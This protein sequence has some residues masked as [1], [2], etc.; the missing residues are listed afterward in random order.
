MNTQQAHSR[1]ARLW[2]SAA[3]VATSLFL[4]PVA[5]GQASASDDSAAAGAAAPETMMLQLYDGSILWGSIVGHDSQTLHFQ[6]LDNGG[7]VRLPWPQLA[8][9]LAD[10]LLDRYGYIDRSGEEII[11]EADRLFLRDG[12][13]VIGAIVNRTEDAIWIKTA[14]STF[15]V[16]KL[17]LRGASTRVKVSAL[18]IYTRD[19]LY[20]NELA[21]LDPTSAQSEWDMSIYCER[22]YDFAHALEHLAAAKALDPNFKPNEIAAAVERNTA[23]VALQTQIDALREIDTL[24]VRGKFDEALKQVEAFVA[25]FETS[26]L[27]S[28]AN[29]K[30]AQVLKAREQKMRERVVEAWHVWLPRLLQTKARSPE[31]TLEAAMAYV[32]EGLSRELLE[33]VTKE[34][35]KTVSSEATPELVKRFW[36]ERQGGR[37]HFASYGQATWLLGDADARKGLDKEDEAANKKP[38]TET[39]TARKELEERIKRYLQNQEVMRKTQGGGSG[40]DEEDRDGFWAEYPSFSKMQWMLAYHVEH[41]GEYQLRDPLF[42]NCPD[43]GGKGVREV[44]SVRGGLNPGGQNGNQGAKGGQISLAKCPTCHHIGVFRRVSYR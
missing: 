4:A 19:E 15:P 2:A 9:A 41:S 22:I 28:K 10:D 12:R 42:S 31:F 38:A 39:D 24:R 34:V 35:A 13:D 26:P 21:N 7:R 29:T 14:Q 40:G 27:R 3:L 17:Q 16:P 37:W 18:E 36:S 23:K 44:V 25:N 11:I 20:K 6:R 43:C 1:C 33:N 30:K 32:D 5:F 8:P